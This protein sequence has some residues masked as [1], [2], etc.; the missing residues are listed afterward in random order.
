M[1]YALPGIE[2]KPLHIQ[3]HNFVSTLTEHDQFCVT[4]CD[5][6][7]ISKAKKEN[8]HSTAGQ[9]KLRSMSNT[10]RDVMDRFIH[11]E[12]HSFVIIC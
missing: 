2:P 5:S 4:K 11:I 8:L 10:K 9:N 1:L 7:M 6:N 12:S 3:V